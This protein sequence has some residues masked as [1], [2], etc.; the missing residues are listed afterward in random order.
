MKNQKEQKKNQKKKDSKD[1]ELKDIITDI[2]CIADSFKNLSESDFK[3]AVAENKAKIEHY[4]A[5]CEKNELISKYKD[6]KDDDIESMQYQM[7]LREK[8]KSRNK[9]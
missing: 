5:E 1:N 2:V 3:I 9:F 8:L 7:Q 6:L 4:N